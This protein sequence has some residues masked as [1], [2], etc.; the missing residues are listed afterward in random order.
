MEPST[1]PPAHSSTPRIS[2][3]GIDLEVKEKESQLAGLKAEIKSRQKVLTTISDRNSEL[4]KF[5]ILE[6]EVS[7]R[8]RQIQVLNDRLIVL[9]AQ[10]KELSLESRAKQ[11]DQE[12]SSLKEAL[13]K[14][15]QE[16]KDSEEK[17]KLVQESWN[18][19]RTMW[20]TEQESYKKTLESYEKDSKTLHD[21][22]DKL[23][24]NLT[25]T[26]A[27]ARK[28]QLQVNESHLTI[29]Q[30][31]MKISNMAQEY[32]SLSSN[33][34]ELNLKIRTNSELQKN[35]N[36]LNEA[37]KKSDFDI[38][39]KF[40]EIE[41]ISSEK[42]KLENVCFEQAQRVNDVS[43]LLSGEVRRAKELEELLKLKEN[44]YQGQVENMSK[45]LQFAIDQLKVIK[46]ELEEKKTLE[47]EVKKRL[48][49]NNQFQSHIRSLESQL[50]QSEN[51]INTIKAQEQTL[52]D[53]ITEL[54]K[55]ISSSKSSHLQ[56]EQDYSSKLKSLKEQL[57]STLIE[58]KVS[59]EN[60]SLKTS[61]IN[62]AI[63]QTH[64]L[65]GKLED[66]KTSIS[67]LNSK[68]SDSEQKCK[69][70]KQKNQSL[71]KEIVENEKVLQTRD[72]TIKEILQKMTHLESDNLSKD[73]ILLQKDSNLSKAVK[74]NEEL[75]K[76][77]QNAHAKFRLQLAE[78][79]KKFETI[80]EAKET[81]IKLL[82]DMMR[83]GQTQ[84]KQREGELSRM[85]NALLPQVS[86]N[87][88]ENKKSIEGAQSKG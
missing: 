73:S 41:K 60:L 62:K 70:L 17:F 63:S 74:E 85:K 34:F 61:E 3:K 39:E 88:L 49:E 58:L 57:E 16:K 18:N 27:E 35:I 81:E 4:E 84:L 40:V 13:F 38:K 32:E 19:Q 23:K 66:A 36:E 31:S 55:Q 71:E 54:E 56:S 37:L 24:L 72:L 75:K 51:K 53:R 46:N 43:A 22:I 20:A 28:F 9:D 45:Q 42:M 10:L 68:L 67:S 14:M 26:S 6:E 50:R 79:I 30:Q 44:S 7:L 78:E 80:L 1:R 76:S 77:M 48:Q 52:K 83:S 33:L 59:Q 65:N 8:D 47:E 64:L 21:E 12:L 25:E 87:N 2:T 29:A 5:K 86:R 15:T 69:M 11:H 82:K